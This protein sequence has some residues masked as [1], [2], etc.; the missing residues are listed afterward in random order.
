MKRGVLE[1]IDWVYT[2]TVLLISLLIFILVM[3][4]NLFKFGPKVVYRWFKKHPQGAPWGPLEGPR[5]SPGA[6]TPSKQ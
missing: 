6:P 2:L 3:I 4:Y 5:S 1:I